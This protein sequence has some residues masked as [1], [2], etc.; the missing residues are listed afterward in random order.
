[1]DKYIDKKMLKYVII[2]VGL[3]VLLIIISYLS[4]RV[5]GG[6][7]YTYEQ[8]EEKMV[9]ATKKYIDNKKKNNLDVLPSAVGTEAEFSATVL[10]NEGYLDELSSYVKGDVICN[11]SVHVFNAGN[12]NYDYEPELICGASYETQ[13]LVNQ[14]IK[15]NDFGVTSGSGLY[16]RIN[17]KFV[18]DEQDFSQGGTDEFE[19]VFRG[20]DVN[21]YVLIDDNYWRIIAID[22]QDNML[23]LFDSRSQK[24]FA[25]DDKYNEIEKKYFGVNTYYDNGLESTA[26]STIQDFYEGKV[27]ILNNAPLSDKIKNVLT[28]FT[29]CVG[30]RSEEDSSTDG[31]T[32][33]K[34]TLD[35]QYMS[36]LPAYYFMS[37]SLDSKCTSVTSKSC[38][39]FNYL[40]G[41]S[42]HWW[43]LTA[44]TANSHAA[45]IVS[46]KNITSNNC[47][48]KANIKPTFML[49]SR[50]LYAEGKG[51]EDEPYKI[52]Y[53]GD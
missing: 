33:C 31:S 24:S 51:T 14:V 3:I 47:H 37:A 6:K 50:V 11:G 10:V 17:G 1:M 16:Q 48:N 29:I 28:P 35:D 25:W 43:L 15:D 44:D 20:E 21:N 12:D 42:Y 9:D 52:K 27:K 39:N 32:E 30:K 18:L 38:G 40:S 7:K 34:E 8:L 41:S 26:Y 5:T 19:Y 22:N 13:K 2:L 53:F 49:G 46:E 36:L 45:Y 4:N 23:L